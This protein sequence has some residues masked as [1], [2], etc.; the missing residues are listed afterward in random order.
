LPA[1][2]E[3]RRHGRLPA[4][5]EAKTGVDVGKV[6]KPDDDLLPYSE[7][8]PKEEGNLLDLL[9]AL[10]QDD[11]I[12]R[13]VG[14]IRKTA[15]DIALTYGEPFFDALVDRLLVQFDPLDTGVLIPRQEVE[16]VARTAAEIRNTSPRLD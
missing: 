15:F 9:E 2:G 8:L 4:E 1:V 12:E 3:G 5:E 6:G 14:I 13:T 16:Q 11:I 10:V 7:G